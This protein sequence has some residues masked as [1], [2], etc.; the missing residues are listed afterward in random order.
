MTHETIVTL[1][2]DSTRGV[3]YLDNS[4]GTRIRISGL[5]PGMPDISKENAPFID[6]DF[7]N[8]KTSWINDM[9]EGN[10]EHP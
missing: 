1:R 7:K 4:K 5:P 6:I 10:D 9:W 2:V 3:L 8:Q